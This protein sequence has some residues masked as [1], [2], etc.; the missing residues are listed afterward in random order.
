MNNDLLNGT[1]LDI[2]AGGKPGDGT[3]GRDRG[4]AA[5][6][7]AAAMARLAA[8]PLHDCSASDR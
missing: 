8:P 6:A 3:G 1:K 2:V 5:K 4:V 7:P